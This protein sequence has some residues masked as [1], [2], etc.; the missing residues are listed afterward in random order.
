MIETGYIKTAHGRDYA[1]C[2]LERGVFTGAVNQTMQ[3]DV[4]VSE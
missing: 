1:D 3:V 4:L 2:S